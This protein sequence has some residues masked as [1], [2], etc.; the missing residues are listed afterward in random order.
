M[1][2]KKPVVEKVDTDLVKNIETTK[3]EKQVKEK[4]TAK[5]TAAKRATT[6]KAKK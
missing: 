3:D 2:K 4:A 5:K 1:S 6:K